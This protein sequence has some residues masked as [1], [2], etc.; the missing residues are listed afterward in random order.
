MNTGENKRAVGARYEKQACEYLEKQGYQ[1]LMC[2]Y[3]CKCGE[4]D[5]IAKDGD[6]LVFCEVK[7]RKNG[8][9]GNPL[10]AVTPAK[11]RTISRCAMTYMLSHGFA[12]VP[13]RF[14]VVGILDD[15][16]TL[17]KNAFEITG[18]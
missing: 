10:E 3:R 12:E 1:I 7:Y 16:I 6:Y 17:I 5:I 13:C 4:I 2:N 11:Q 9:K 14:D 15:E 18:V 8:K